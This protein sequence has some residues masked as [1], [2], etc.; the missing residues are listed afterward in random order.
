MAVKGFKEF[1]MR[2]NIVDLAVA[3]IIGAAFT[4]VVN[5]FATDFIGGLIAEVT[6]KAGAEDGLTKIDEVTIP[7]T[8]IVWGTTV[9]ALINFV[10][11]ASIVYFFVVVPMKRVME[12]ASK[13][14]EE[15]AN[16]PSEVELL[17]EIR[18]LLSKQ[19]V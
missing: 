18:D 3:V 12:L 7:G 8:N 17:K 10:V 15:K 4:A 5:A 19:K 2:G 11:V 14:E 1:L 6:S 13:E 9:T 16:E